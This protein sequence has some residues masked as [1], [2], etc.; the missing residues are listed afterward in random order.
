MD[1]FHEVES[2]P[3]VDAWES[4]ASKEVC[5]GFCYDPAWRLATLCALECR[6]PLSQNLAKTHKGPVPSH[7]IPFQI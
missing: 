1:W 2:L 5:L 3:A 7:L 6:P 4:V